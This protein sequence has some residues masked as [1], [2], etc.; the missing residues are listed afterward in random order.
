MCHSAFDPVLEKRTFHAERHIRTGEELRIIY[1]N[2]IN[3]TRSQHQAV[4]DKWECTCSCPVCE[5]P[6][7]GRKREEKHALLLVLNQRLAILTQ[8]DGEESW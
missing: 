4:L 8:F 5:D 2:S 6:P 1:I 7:D 3:R